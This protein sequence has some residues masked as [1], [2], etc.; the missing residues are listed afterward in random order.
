MF[1][2]FPEK[3]IKVLFLAGWYPNRD[4]PISGIFIKRHAEAVS[5]Y[6]DVAVLYIHHWS[7]GKSA[8]IDYTIEDG[9][10]TI[11]VYPDSFHI[12]NRLLRYL[13]NSIFNNILINSYKGLKVVQKEF[14]R[15]DVVHV[16]VSLPM[17]ILALILDFFKGIPFIVTEHYTDFIKTTK[18]P[19]YYLK[20]KLILKKTKYICTV[21]QP[22]KIDMQTF[23]REKKY[24]VI[25]NVV[26]IDF[27]SPPPLK[28]NCEKKKILHISLLDDKQKNVS[29]I[30]FAIHQ[31]S[32]LR[33]NF[34][35]NIVGDGFDRMKLE[36]LAIHLG[37]KDTIVFFK[38]RVTNEKILDFFHDSDFFIL[39]SNYETF[40]VACAE[41]LAA[42]I[43]VIATRCGGPEDFINENVGILIEK[44][45]KEELISAINY[46]LDNSGKYDPWVLH[47][48]AKERFGYEVVG[49]MFFNLYLKVLYGK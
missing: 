47:E 14:G 5:R 45:N 36:N 28:K 40:C 24:K 31:I 17:G 8:K 1:H 48:Y 23:H 3:R 20:L 37:I 39:N 41:A 10:R 25:P 35:L 49:K 6:C 19:F 16:N 29:G 4:N 38:G 7:F 11:R 43:P 12:N 27:F 18:N 42:G 22:L 2:T 46:M 32:K 33:D 21:S 15:P 34:E 9:I 13:F 26:N 44:G 30:L